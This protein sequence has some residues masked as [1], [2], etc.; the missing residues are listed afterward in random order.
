[1]T[2]TYEKLQMKYLG[3]RINDDWRYDEGYSVLGT[4]DDEILADFTEI[5]EKIVV[6]R[7][8]CYDRSTTNDDYN[9]DLV[10]LLDDLVP[11]LEGAIEF[12]QV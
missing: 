10:L 3:L 12:L 5:N 1:M 8:K 6:L 4:I 2:I 9:I 7:E 11:Y